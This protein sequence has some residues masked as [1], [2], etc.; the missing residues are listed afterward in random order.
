M[1]LIQKGA[2]LLRRYQMLHKLGYARIWCCSKLYPPPPRGKFPPVWLAVSRPWGLL[3]VGGVLTED[4][5][6]EA[7]SKGIYPLYDKHPVKWFSC[8][9]RMVLF[10]EKL[11]LE[12][13]VQRLMRDGRFRITFD[14]AFEEV[15]R[16]CSD[17]AWTWLIPERISVAVAM[18]ERGQA[19]SVEA[20]NR[21]GE[22]VG[23]AFGTDMGR[24]FIGE[25]V[26]HR[27][28]NAGKVAHAC[29]YSHLRHW[30]YK[31]VDIQAYSRHHEKMGFEEIPRQEY[32]H[33]LRELAGVDIR[34]GKWVVDER[35][36]V[37]R[38]NPSMPGSQE[39]RHETG[40]CGLENSS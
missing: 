38:W 4:T 31:M 14:T 16:A 40:E 33:R 15:V 29:L 24:I 17:R 36:D 6:L 9:P 18:H 10:L 26:F 34:Y 28:S 27:E 23:G 22:L 3:A 12:K 19:H 35:L 13:N 21:D 7:F 37:G 32:I 25:S 39:K 11:K 2:Q 8:N 30:G 5:L 1:G 20:W